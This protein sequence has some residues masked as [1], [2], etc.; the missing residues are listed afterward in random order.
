[1]RL[2]DLEAACERY[3]TDPKNRPYSILECCSHLGIDAGTL[4]AWETSGTARRRRL[5]RRIRDGVAVAWEKGELPAS[6]ALHLM[7]SYLGDPAD[8]TGDTP[9]PP[10]EIVVRVVGDL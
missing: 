6:L 3:F 10:I 2:V 4:K 8:P 9:G 5:A 1:M 7:R